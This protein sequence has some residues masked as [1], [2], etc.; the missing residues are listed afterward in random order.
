MWGGSHF[1]ED[2][3][4]FSS[5]R[6]HFVPR[7]FSSDKRSLGCFLV[8]WKVILVKAGSK[9][10]N[11]SMHLLTQRGRGCISWSSLL[12]AAPPG[13]AVLGRLQGG[14]RGHP[15]QAAVAWDRRLCSHPPNL[16]QK[17]GGAG[18]LRQVEGFL[19]ALSRSAYEGCI[20]LGFWGWEVSA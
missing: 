19:P 5:E 16:Q 1:G 20:A 3:L 11:Q 6:L 9:S 14:S 12:G 18:S 15:R 4:A 2:T 7:P 17:D 13:P 10:R 8:F